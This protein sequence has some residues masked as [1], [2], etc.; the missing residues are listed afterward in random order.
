MKNN[1]LSFVKFDDLLLRYFG[2][3]VHTKFTL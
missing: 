1:E 3:Q 2:R